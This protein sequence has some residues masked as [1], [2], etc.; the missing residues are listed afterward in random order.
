MSLHLQTT[1]EGA[2]A[3]EAV[4]SDFG[5]I[6]RDKATVVSG[7][8]LTAGTVLGR[9]TASGKYTL[10]DP[11]AADGSQNATAILLA[12]C[13][14]SAGDARTVVLARLA[15]VKADLLVFKSGITAPQKA[16]ALAAL[17]AQN[18]IAR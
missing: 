10:H 13:N 8:N 12:D 15:E 11:A 9:I 4:L 18:L 2:H 17:A 6:S 3:F 7:Q 14:A 16:A 1:T 5:S